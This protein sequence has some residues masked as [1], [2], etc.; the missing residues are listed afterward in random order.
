MS[1]DGTMLEWC[2]A[3]GVPDAALPLSAAVADTLRPGD[4][5]LVLVSSMR[6]PTQLVA[7]AH[8]TE[9]GQSWAASADGLLRNW[10]L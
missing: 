6:E 1:N 5:A 7:F 4:D 9:G 10:R 2:L 3:S 8:T